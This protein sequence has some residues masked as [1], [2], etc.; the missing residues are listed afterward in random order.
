M[1]ALT[2][3]FFLLFI[4]H[5]AT[6]QIK[7]ILTLGATSETGQLMNHH[8]TQRRIPQP[9]VR[10]GLPMELKRSRLILLGQFSW[11]HWRAEDVKLRYLVPETRENLWLDNIQFGVGVDWQLKTTIRL[12]PVIAV[13][14]TVGMPLRMHYQLVGGNI[15]GLPSSQDI[16][17]G[18]L[19]AAGWQIQPGLQYVLSEHSSIYLRYVLGTQ[20]QEFY[21]GGTANPNGKLLSGT[22]VGWSIGWSR[23]L[24]N[25]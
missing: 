5:L 15:S 23:R 2:T 8:L 11:Q 9:F 10:I 21:F 20:Y 6:A 16:K 3:L 1:R 17:G 22:Y 25:G 13:F 14:C 24:F 19:L 4:S 12:Q 7:P 18:G